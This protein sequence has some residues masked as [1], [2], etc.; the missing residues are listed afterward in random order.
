[1]APVTMTSRYFVLGQILTIIRSQFSPEHSVFMKVASSGSGFKILDMHSLMEGSVTLG[2][3]V[4]VWISWTNWSQ[5]SCR[6]LMA[7]RRPEAKTA[8]TR[9]TSWRMIRPHSI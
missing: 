1:M 4:P 3:R 6:N 2:L 8:P 9:R 7:R 5:L